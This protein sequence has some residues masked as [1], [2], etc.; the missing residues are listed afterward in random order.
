MA[1][2]VAKV[3]E[4]SLA[5]VKLV[6]LNNISFYGNTAGDNI[7]HY[8]MDCVDIVVHKNAEKLVRLYHAVLYHLAH[9][10]N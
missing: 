6:R 7:V 2:S 5:L 4:H 3:Q 10:V 1:K 9:S 8:L